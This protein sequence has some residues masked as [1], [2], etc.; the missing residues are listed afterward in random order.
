MSQC[1]AI[2]GCKFN[3][4]R[5]KNECTEDPST[6]TT[7]FE[8]YLSTETDN[9]FADEDEVAKLTAGDRAPMPNLRGA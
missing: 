2:K 5:G 1:Q 7:A 3:Q 6:T 9:D 8:A 4:K